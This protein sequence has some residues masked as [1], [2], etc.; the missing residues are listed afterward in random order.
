VVAPL[1]PLVIERMR[2][3]LGQRD[4]LLLSLMGYQ[5][6]RPGE[7]LALRDDSVRERTLLVDRAVSFGEEK[8]TK[9]D[10]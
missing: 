2:A 9:T 7:A 3:Q 1:A 6:L 10:H 8:A 5:G 4:A